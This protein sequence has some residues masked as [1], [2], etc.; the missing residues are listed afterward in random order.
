MGKP[1]TQLVLTIISLFFLQAV[2]SATQNELTAGDVRILMINTASLIDDIDTEIAT[3][4][5]MVSQ[6]VPCP[7]EN[8]D[9]C[10]D[11]AALADAELSLL[12]AKNNAAKTVLQT[13]A[14]DYNSD[15]PLSDVLKKTGVALEIING[16]I[17]VAISQSDQI[18]SSCPDDNGYDIC[19]TAKNAVIHSLATVSREYQSVKADY[20]TLAAIP[21]VQLT[22]EQIADK[23]KNDRLMGVYS[24]LGEAE[25]MR[26]TM[27]NLEQSGASAETL[28]ASRMKLAGM[29]K[30]LSDTYESVLMDQR[31]KKDFWTNWDY[32]TLKKNQGDIETARQLYA[33]AFSSTNVDEKDRKEFLDKLQKDSQG[34]LKLT[35]PPKADDKVVK[36]ISQ[37][38]HEQYDKISNKAQWA[39]YSAYMSFHSS[40]V[41][42]LAK[43]APIVN[44]M[45]KFRDLITGKEL[46]NSA[47]QAGN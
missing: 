22:P 46:E 25:R 45:K 27:K 10:S 4:Q 8:E 44:D 28:S 21:V 42:T 7:C 33:T 29:E 36:S 40:V 23:K 14:N 13:A 24:K 32:A 20:D 2:C 15:V 30:E 26:E 12:Q 5:S 34:E 6:I 35:Q 19:P 47:G 38:M 11:A 1:A 9:P 31:Y 18:P 43:A 37:S 17:K 16:G 41:F 3:M 39:G